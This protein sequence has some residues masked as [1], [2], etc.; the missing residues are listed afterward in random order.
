MKRLLLI[1][2]LL[3]LA[4]CKAEEVKKDFSKLAEQKT[5]VVA[6]SKTFE[7]S[8][9][10][11]NSVQPFFDQTARMIVELLDQETPTQAASNLYQLISPKDLCK[12]LILP[13]SIWDQ[14]DQKCNNPIGYLCSDEL[15]LLPIIYKK[16]FT[17]SPKDIQKQLQTADVCKDWLK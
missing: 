6:N 7:V 11:Q 17:L 16:L 9:Q 15:K 5:L 4:S 10:G 1:P 12:K 3:L 2:L 13:K 8:E 14:L